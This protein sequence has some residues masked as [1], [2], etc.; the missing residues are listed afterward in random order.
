MKEFSWNQTAPAALSIDR[1]QGDA[2]PQPATGRLPASAQ[3]CARY[4]VVAHG[5]VWFIKFDDEEYGPYRSRSEAMLFAI[6]AAQKLGQLG[7]ESQVLLMGEN[8]HARP[9]WTYG[10]DP[11][12]PRM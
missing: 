4:Y 7:D 2:M 8:G 12:P 9:E 10:R 1:Q 6:D 5:D 11:Y 3:T